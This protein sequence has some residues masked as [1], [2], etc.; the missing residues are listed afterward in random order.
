MHERILVP[1]DGSKTGGAVL[2]YLQVWC[3]RLAPDLKTEVILLQ[4]VSSLTHYVIAGEASARVPHTERELEQ[5]KEKA[6]GYLAKVGEGLKGKG[7][8]VKTKVA[9]GK[10][11]D[12][13]IETADQINID[14]IAMSTHGR[15]GL[16]RWAFGSVTEQVLREGNVPILIVRAPKETGET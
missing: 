7:A 11:A 6:K 3:P 8:T 4:V 14:L 13:I 9:V 10:A 15:S 2:P 5:I 1:L 16:G 12:E